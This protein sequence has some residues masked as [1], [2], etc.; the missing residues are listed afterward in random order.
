MGKVF[1]YSLIE[2]LVLSVRNGKQ[3]RFRGGL[4]V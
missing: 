4:N 3:E 2:A 1:K